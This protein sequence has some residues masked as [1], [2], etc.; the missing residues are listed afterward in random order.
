MQLLQRIG[1]IGYH[2]NHPSH[3]VAMVA[4]KHAFVVS[5]WPQ[6]FSHG[7]EKSFNN[8][9]MPVLEL[10]NKDPALGA[11]CTT[12]LCQGLYYMSRERVL[13][14]KRGLD[15]SKASLQPIWDS[16]YTQ[17]IHTLQCDLYP[18][19]Q[20]METKD[21][22]VRR[23]KEFLIIL[24]SFFLIKGH[25]CLVLIYKGLKF[26]HNFEMAKALGANLLSSIIIRP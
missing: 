6:D 24:N 2:G 15:L 21:F 5:C 12:S 11:T 9:A 17:N 20:T 4:D 1:I 16:N 14:T 3:L 22:S 26:S 13:W 8:G 19:P 18:P 10:A 25:T 23:L 7:L